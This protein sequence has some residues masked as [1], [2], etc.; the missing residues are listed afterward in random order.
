MELDREEAVWFR[1]PREAVQEWQPS[2]VVDL[3]Q[4]EQL[5]CTK[6]VIGGAAR[7]VST[8]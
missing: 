6:I 7:V 8:I 5:D 2:T 3:Y 1:F 4:Q